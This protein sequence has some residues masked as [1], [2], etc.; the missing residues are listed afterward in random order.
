MVVTLVAVSH[1]I[2]I[3]LIAVGLVPWAAYWLVAV[4]AGGLAGGLLLRSRAKAKLAKGHPK[5][6]LERATSDAAWVADRAEDVG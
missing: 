6:A 5:A 2:A 3:T 4:A 1:A